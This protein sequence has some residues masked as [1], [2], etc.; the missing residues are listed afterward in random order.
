MGEVRYDRFFTQKLLFFSN[1][2]HMLRHR[3]VS[4]YN[5][6][7]PDGL[8]HDCTAAHD[9]ANMGLLPSRGVGCFVQGMIRVCVWCGGTAMM[10]TTP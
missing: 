7:V 3:T 4:H 2:M 10:G 5:E 9:A 8:L 1:I 6:L